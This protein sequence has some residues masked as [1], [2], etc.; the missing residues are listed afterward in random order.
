MMG[1]F[2]TSG[3]VE[4]SGDERG[5]FESGSNR[6]GYC[7]SPSNDPLFLEQEHCGRSMLPCTKSIKSGIKNAAPQLNEG[8]HH[9]LQK[10]REDAIGV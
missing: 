7:S 3:T 1:T 5:T 9:F 2:L 6:R 10:V 4:T 8:R